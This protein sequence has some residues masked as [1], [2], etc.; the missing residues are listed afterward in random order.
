MSGV[1]TRRWSSTILA[2]NRSLKRW[3]GGDFMFNDARV[4][5]QS[6]KRIH[7][8][9]WICLVPQWAST[10]SVDAFT[11]AL[12]TGPPWFHSGPPRL[13]EMIFHDFWMSF[14][15]SRQCR[16]TVP[17]D[18]VLFSVQVSTVYF[19]SY[20]SGSGSFYVLKKILKSKLLSLRFLFET[21]WERV[22][23]NLE[24]FNLFYYSDSF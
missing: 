3:T 7:R 20:G 22:I 9:L 17:F 2:S 14:R 1:S 4:N 12:W 19:S 13:L 10:A 5:F 23:F 15:S 11:A 8:P 24:L 18:T 16:G 6:S 21:V